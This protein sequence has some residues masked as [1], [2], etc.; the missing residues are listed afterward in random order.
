[1][2]LT[3]GNVNDRKPVPDLL[4]KLFGKIFADKGYISQP[5]YDQLLQTVGVQLITKRKS[6]SN[7]KAVLG[8]EVIA[9]LPA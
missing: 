7:Q 6:N 9:C 8:R 1:M 5:L 4:R 3:P 2:L